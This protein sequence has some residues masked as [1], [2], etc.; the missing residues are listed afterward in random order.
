[1]RYN[2]QLMQA[3]LHDKVQIAKA[4][5]VTLMGLEEAPRGYHDFD[6]GAARKFVLDPH[7][8]VAVA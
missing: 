7:G 4:V 2:R 5:N 3:I 1:M 6:Q 8:M